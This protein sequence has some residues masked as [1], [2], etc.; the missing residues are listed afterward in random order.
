MTTKKSLRRLVEE[1]PHSELDAARRYLEYLRDSADPLIR[2]LLEAQED[3]EEQ[4]SEDRDA[5]QEAREDIKAGRFATL[6]EVKADFD[7]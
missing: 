6:D 1:L 3:E 4:T 2:T 5:L 7:L